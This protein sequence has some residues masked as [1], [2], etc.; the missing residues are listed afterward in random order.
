M[1]IR[2]GRN[3]LSNFRKLIISRIAIYFERNPLTLGKI[4]TIVHINET[5]INH[6]IKA[7]RGRTPRNQTWLLCI[8]DTVLDKIMPTP[9]L[10]KKQITTQINNT[11]C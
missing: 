4:G 5:M 10:S 2:I 6:K 11:W 9:V 8:V 1:F 7:N 3:T